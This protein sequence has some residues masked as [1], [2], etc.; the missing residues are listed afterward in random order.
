[1]SFGR[2]QQTSR[3]ISKCRTVCLG[4][5]IRIP[6]RCDSRY[7]RS[8]A[9]VRVYALFALQDHRVPIETPVN[10]KKRTLATSDP[11]SIT[12]CSNGF[13]RK[14]D[15]DSSFSRSAVRGRDGGS[16]RIRILSSLI[17]L[18]IRCESSFTQTSLNASRESYLN[19]LRR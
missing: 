11:I 2:T 15:T 12:M 10:A 18:K 13:R 8:A 19:R 14:S 3:S 9:L 4:R 16:W 5:V 17:P 7:S 6:I 1:M